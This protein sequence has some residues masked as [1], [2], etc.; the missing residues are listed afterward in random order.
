MTVIKW[1]E[2]IEKQLLIIVVF[3]TLHKMHEAY[4]RVGV[5]TKR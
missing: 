3:E 2:E 1:L 5:G 4:K